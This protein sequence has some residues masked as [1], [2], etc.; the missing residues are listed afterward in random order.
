MIKIYEDVAEEFLNGNVVFK[1]IAYS[2]QNTVDEITEE[3]GG[4]TYTINTSVVSRD[5][6]IVTTKE[7]YEKKL[8]THIYNPVLFLVDTPLRLAYLYGCLNIE[9]KVP[10]NEDY[11]FWWRKLKTDEWRKWF[12]VE[13]Y[14]ENT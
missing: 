10:R 9:F 13:R 7:D 1:I 11:I 8:Y 6:G 4:N 2:E 14:S 3:E 5:I 12:V